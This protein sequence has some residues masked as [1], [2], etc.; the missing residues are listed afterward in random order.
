MISETVSSAVSARSKTRSGCLLLAVILTVLACHDNPYDSIEIR[1]Q[2]LNLDTSTDR[3]EAIEKQFAAAGIVPTRIRAIPGNVLDIRTLILA[4][5]YDPGLFTKNNGQEARLGELGYN[6]SFLQ[7][8]TE[9]AL[10]PGRLI[11]HFDDDVVF[12]PTLD[13]DFR[14]HLRDVPADWNILFLGCNKDRLVGKGWHIKGFPGYEPLPNGDHN[15]CRSKTMR[16][17]LGTAWQKLSKDCTTG[18]YAIVI[19]ANTAKHLLPKVLSMPS[20]TDITMI[21]EFD[22]LNAYCIDPALVDL[23]SF[24]STIK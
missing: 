15:L 22:S 19:N 1:Y 9:V 18:S 8:L 17:V 10:N 7:Y 3:R 23:A 24:A 2:Y 16:P 14:T 6:L 11:V 13:A 4:K 21:R 12:S 5:L 20:Q